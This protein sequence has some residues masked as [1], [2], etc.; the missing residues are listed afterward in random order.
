[1]SLVKL[2]PASGDGPGS[3]GPRPPPLPRRISPAA[4]DAYR[5]CPRRAWFLHVARVPRRERP[6]PVLVVGNA[7]PRPSLRALLVRARLSRRRTS[8]AR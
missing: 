8:R 5:T 3:R 7:V 6:S 1:M 2:A 4:I